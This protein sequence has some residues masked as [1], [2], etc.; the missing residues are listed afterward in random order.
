MSSKCK[1]YFMKKIILSVIMVVVLIPLSVMAQTYSSLWNQVKAAESKDL[2]KTQMKILGQIEAKAEAEKNYG[3]L[4]KAVLQSA[5]IETN[6]SPDS[7]RPV[8]EGLTAREHVATDSV[9]KAIY[10]AVL[11]RIYSDNK[12]EL[13][14]D[15]D[16]LA[17]K[18]RRMAMACPGRLAAARATDYEPLVVKGYNASVFGGDMLSV[19][20]YE[21]E[22]FMTMHEWYG[23]AGQRRA[24]CITGLEL[25]R[26]HRPQGIHSV[27]KSDYLM[28][29]DSLLTVYSDLDV[30]GEAA[31]ERY[32]YLKSCRDVTVEDKIGY[33]HYA[34]DKWGG[35]Q[36]SNYLREQ[37]K[38]LTSP[39][40]LVSMNSLESITPYTNSTIKL[41]SLRNLSSLTMNVYRVAVNGDYDGTPSNDNDYKALKPK[42]TL[43]SDK[44]QTRTYMGHP[45]Y[46]LFNDS[47]V[48]GSLPVGVYMLEFQTVP[49]TNAVRVMYYVSDVYCIEQPLPGDSVRFV[50]VSA[51]TGQPLPG[52]K[53]RLST[54]R[55]KVQPV[56]LTCDTNG[57]AIYKEASVRRERIYAYTETDRA[58]RQW[59]SYVSFVKVDEWSDVERT[60]VF[61]DRRIYRP[62]QTVHVAAVIYKNK[63][64]IDNTAVERKTVKAALRDANGK[65]VEEK[66]L[67]TDKYGSCST[68][69]VLPVGRLN[70]NFAVMVNGSVERI[71]VEEYKRPTFY[72]EFPKIN[73]RYGNG[74]TLMVRAKAM[75]YSGIPVQG[76]D[77]NYTVKR[78]IALW[79][80]YSSY[81]WGGKPGYGYSGETIFSGKATTDGNGLFNVDIPVVLPD[82]G[83]IRPMFYEFVVEADVTDI[84]GETHSGSMSVPLGNRTTVL[85]STLPTQVLAD[86]LVQVTFNLR[87]TAGMDVSADVRFRFD[88]VGE[89]LETHTAQPYLLGSRL[90][91]G[92][93][94][95]TAISESDTLEQ[96][97]VVFG[98]DDTVPCTD[99]PDWFYVSAESFPLDGSPV[100]VQAGSSADS[101]HIVYTIISG[102]KT[103]E[104]GSVDRSNSLV[105]RKFTYKEDY[106]NGLVLNYVWVK[107]GRCYRHSAT[108]GRPL[109]DKRLTM[110]WTTFRD[111]LTPGQKEEWSLSVMKPDGRP[112]DALLIA[113]MYDKSLDQIIGHT[114]N[115]KPF[116]WLRNPYTWWYSSPS[117]SFMIGAE[118]SWK[119]LNWRA[120]EPS[121]FDS[122]LFPL[123]LYYRGNLMMIGKSVMRKSRATSASPVMTADQKAVQY[124]AAEAVFNAVDVAVATGEATSEDMNEP[125]GQAIQLRENLN[126]T[127]FFYPSARTDS[128]GNVTLAFT[129]PESL[130]TWRFM[131]MAHTADMFSGILEGEAVARKDVMVQPNMPRF[132]RMG[133]KA[134][135]SARI[136]NTGAGVAKGK[137]LMQLINPETEKIIYSQSHDIKVQPDSTVA[138]TFDYS[139]DGTCTLLICKI[140]VSGKSF[141]DGEQHYLP[142]LPD[143]ERVTVTVP[144]SQNGP[145]TKTIDISGLF[146]VKDK[147][148]RLTVEYTNNPAWM[149][150]QAL[151][152]MGTPSEDNAVEQS[153][154]LYANTIAMAIMSQNPK[155]KKTFDQWRMERG[156]ETSLMSNLEKNSE[157]KDI[158]LAETPWMAEADNEAEQKQ[159]LAIFFD[160]SAMTNRMTSATDK[161]KDLQ[162]P[163]G[164]WSW[165]PGMDGNLYMTVNIATTLVRMNAMAGRQQ[166]TETMLNRAF[167]FLGRQ[168]IKEVADMKEAERKG[169][170]STFPGITALQYLYA[171][172][173]DG[174]KQ[175]APVQSACDYLIGLLKRDICG[176]SIYEKALTAIILA[177]HGDITKGREYV[178][179]LKEYSVYTDD[180]GRY[181]DTRRASYSWYDYKIPTEV[182]AIEAIKL[183]TPDDRQTVDEM[184]RWLLRQKQTQAWSTPVNSVNAIYAFLFDNTRELST[185]EQPLLAI[186]GQQLDLP[187]ATAGM[188]YVKTVVT[189]PEGKTFTATKT[190]DG[191]SWGALY[192]Q[193]M[194][195]T[196]EIETTGNAITVKKEIIPKAGG[197]PSVGSRITV[198]ITIETS[199]DLDFVYVT[200]RRAACMEPVDQ[201]SGYRRG[202][203]RSPKDNAT[204]YY[205][206]CMPKGK[207]IIETEY[208]ID[209]AGLYHT[210]TCTAGC[211]YAPEYRATA[212]SQTLIVKE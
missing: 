88:G 179:S 192:A 18:Y 12:A 178:K 154:S 166:Q 85:T 164:S 181:Y 59:D 151:P 102:N 10:A 210:G 6:V 50:V 79:W 38:A 125:D 162:N 195:N 204:N 13:G 188:G 190:S 49:V 63:K 203:Y 39:R 75:A 145:G 62:G 138:V 172:T 104:S 148:A 89:W 97:F 80:R 208:Y 122:S 27:R 207:H 173:L 72:V 76:A 134:R 68:D 15:A 165:C 92:H 87:N 54:H 143:R 183:V 93:H 51:T 106:G 121:R 129:L 200:D 182:A 22:D 65:V 100:T 174:R 169:I 25:L 132:I 35:W 21:V 140:T 176:Q 66:E 153:M 44:G 56:T 194:Q 175:P 117:Y 67:I 139:P 127:A 123:P 57:E 9:L 135:L 96:D 128:A 124:D 64:G 19:I 115:F 69:F 136:S 198:R 212:K 58:A 77:V 202:A 196:A 1:C 137:A 83:G 42:L 146:P 157:L 84:S 28:W 147:T 197:E 160:E 34:I 155:I 131:G 43:L 98:L 171:V 99:T 168:Y 95:L 101:V 141:S 163:D 86:S 16:T 158:V 3:Q 126:E 73:E 184:R 120:F 118:Q 71:R 40:F 156:T 199:R 36:R 33:I 189:R 186:D 110:K 74:D 78:N 133:D 26:Q 53:I 55:S 209:R 70:G 205:F 161:L 47:I 119:S 201:L 61:T 17:S 46:E 108:I 60:S 105:N 150:V 107:D 112:A 20:G 170:N 130:T 7:L 142:V 24:S 114:W 81:S 159:K 193:Y 152:A 116:T 103:I 109:P 90:V 30:A 94:H 11:Y 41:E 29:L 211:A 113:T 14:D 149:M 31:I 48:L 187:Q 91:S 82:D 206:D 177:R 2:P 167:D 32:D 37:E 4:L 144:F 180:M 185:K 52:A 5:K 8:V 23:S 191:T 111:R 45:E